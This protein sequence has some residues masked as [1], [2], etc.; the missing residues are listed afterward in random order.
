LTI[1]PE[2]AKAHALTGLKINTFYLHRALPYAT[3]Q[4]LTALTKRHWIIYQFRLVL[5]LSAT[6]ADSKPFFGK[7]SLK[8]NPLHDWTTFVWLVLPP[9]FIRGY[10]YS[11]TCL[12]FKTYKIVTKKN[13]QL[14]SVITNITL[15]FLEKKLSKEIEIFFENFHYQVIFFSL[16]WKIHKKPIFFRNHFRKIKLY[17]WM[18]GR[19]ARINWFFCRLQRNGRNALTKFLTRR[20]AIF[21]GNCF[22]S[23]ST[24]YDGKKWNPINE[25]CKKNFVRKKKQQSSESEECCFQ[26][27]IKCLLIL[28]ITNIYELLSCDTKIKDTFGFY[29]LQII[30]RKQH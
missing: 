16:T 5:L 13:W 3:A 12:I 1:S 17:K 9:H 19:L 21:F 14:N 15:F 18:I 2:R 29:K 20:G 22:L 26:L 30:R 11:N 28:K 24:I 27:I 4:R 6:V 23:L 25:I 7:Y 8:S 10:S